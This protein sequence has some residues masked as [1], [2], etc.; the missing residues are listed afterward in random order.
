LII[1]PETKKKLITTLAEIG[2]QLGPTA[3][4]DK[5]LPEIHLNIEMPRESRQGYS[6]GWNE[7]VFADKCPKA[8]KRDVDKTNEENPNGATPSRRRNGREER[9]TIPFGLSQIRGE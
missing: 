4:P 1:N 6:I 2:N 3:E 5:L 7:R 9:S 8:A